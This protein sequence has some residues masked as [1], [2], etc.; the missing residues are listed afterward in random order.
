VTASEVEPAEERGPT[1][2]A[3]RTCVACGEHDDRGALIRLVASPEGEV[4]ID[5]RARLPGRGAWVHPDRGCAAKIERDPRRLA[6]VLKSSVRAERLEQ[7]LVEAVLRAVLDG[8]SLASAGGA[9]VG[10]HD[11][12]EQGLRSGRISELAFASD[13]SARTV[14]DVTRSAGDRPITRLPLDKDALGARVGQ[15]PRAVVG[16]VDAP[17][18]RHLREQ[19]RRLRSLG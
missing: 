11:A 15:A 16:L 18:F 12:V 7:R 6:R 9:L 8:M 5:L 4:A 2:V 1:R 3:E 19:L 17:G 14:A 10:G 13:A